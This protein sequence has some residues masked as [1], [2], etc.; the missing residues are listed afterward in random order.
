[1]KKKAVFI[2]F[3]IFYTA[4]FANK[5]NIFSKINLPVDTNVVLPPAWAFG[6][7]YGGY[8]NQRQSIER[9]KEIQNHDYPIDAYWIDSWFWSF[10]DKGQGPKKYIDFVADTVNFPDRK[11]MW[12]FMSKNG[13]KGGFWIWNCILKTGNEQAFNDFNSK[14]FFS[15]V[16]TEN[17]TWHNNST[18][19]AMFQSGGKNT[20]TECGNI[21]FS[22]P[23][24]VAYFNEKM[25]IFFD[26]GADFLKLDRTSA[27]D[28][29]KA[30]F[31]LS[32]LYGKET[33]G[34]GFILSHTGGMENDTYKCYPA[35]W[36]DDTRSD[37]NTEN[38]TKKFNSW[39]PNIAFKE[40]IAMF[41]DHSKK[42]SKIPFLTNDMG[43]FDMGLTN[44]LDEE[45]FIRWMEFSMFTP[46]V[47]VFSQPENPTANLPYLISE[48]ADTLFRKYA[49]LRMQLFP[50][51]YSYAHNVR[52]EAKQMMQSYQNNPYDYYFGDEMFLAPVYKQFA[53]KRELILP[54]GKWINFWTNQTVDGGEKIEVSAPIDQIPLFIKQGAIIPMRQYAPSVEKGTNDT[55]IIHIYTG[56]D[57]QFTL[58]EDDGTSNDYLNG[59]YATT[60]FILNKGTMSDNL[61]IEPT[62][63]DFKG[64]QLERVVKLVIHSDKKIK[65]IEFSG[66]NVS[67]SKSYHKIET[68]F[69][70]LKKDKENIFIVKY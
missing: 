57:G 69:C 20:G 47:E 61:L 34:R 9:I 48:R 17:N 49:H 66:G 3:L 7:F 62:N 44:E 58:I 5:N 64:M 35:K 63:G 11:L 33:K 21:D 54:N 42:S 38:P 19:T 59:G 4:I 32:Q 23:K 70:K 39:V 55:L 15:K 68:V 52:L 43:G 30:M 26:E 2:L 41:T 65:K 67:E 37:W 56:V 24:A 16:Y 27:I 25:K 45:L 29:C 28:V 18:S 22:N 53:T 50:Y 12:N 8:T 6:V 31:G 60:H 14:G 13:I 46:I 10:A 36:T 40:N 51:I 1:M